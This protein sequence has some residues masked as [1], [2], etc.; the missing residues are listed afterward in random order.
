MAV[1]KSFDVEFNDSLL[2]M[3]SWNNPRYEGSKL[4]GAQVNYYN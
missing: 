1:S 3:A 4:T 2:D